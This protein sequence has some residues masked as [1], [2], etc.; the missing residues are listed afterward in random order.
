ML[1]SMEVEFVGGVGGVGW[2][3]VGGSYCDYIANLSSSLAEV[4]L[5][6]GKNRCNCLLIHLNSIELSALIITIEALY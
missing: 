3:G 5:R 2:G 4:E 1:H 6:F